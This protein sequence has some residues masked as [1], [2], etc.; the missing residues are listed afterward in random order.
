MYTPTEQRHIPKAPS[1]RRLSAARQGYGRRWQEARKHFLSSNPLCVVC[2]REGVITLATHVDH[3][4]PHRGDM[5]LF[6]NRNNWQPLCASCHSN[7]TNREDGGF[8]NIT[9]VAKAIFNK[10]Y[11][12]FGNIYLG[13]N[14]TGGVFKI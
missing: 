13:D 1:Y 14:N 3:I 8:G 7:K 5:K 9:A 2:K 10:K 4:K 6:W 12:A 11:K